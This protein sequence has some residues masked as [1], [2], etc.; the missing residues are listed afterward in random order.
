MKR[1]ASSRRP[2]PAAVALTVACLCLA[3]PGEAATFSW[4]VPGPVYAPPAWSSQATGAQGA[5]AW[6][7]PVA[8]REPVFFRKG[9]VLLTQRPSDE[10]RLLLWV[11]RK[12]LVRD[13]LPPPL[14]AAAKKELDAGG[15]LLIVGHTDIV[16]PR[17]L[18]RSLSLE[19]ARDV[20]KRL[21]AET[22]DAPWR[23]QIMGEGEDD[24]RAEG[25]VEVFAWKPLPPPE[26]GP[27]QAV[28]LLSPTPGD[29]AGSQLLAMMDSE[30]KEVVL[31]RVEEGAAWVWG[32][33]NPSAILRMP[34]PA[35]ALNLAVGGLFPDGRY[36]S[37]GEWKAPATIRELT[38]KVDSLEAGWARLSGRLPAGYESLTIWAGGI[39]YP[40]P[41]SGGKF[42]VQVARFVADM[43]V[44]AQ[45]VDPKGVTVVGPLLRLPAPEEGAPRLVAVLVWDGEGVDLDLHAWRGLGHTQPSDPD[46]RLSTG[47]AEGVRLLFDGD[48]RGRASAL[49]ADD[50][51][52]DLEIEVR[53]FS[54]LG[55]G[56]EATLY[57]IEYPADP[58]LRQGRIFG[59][60]RLS[61]RPLEERWPALHLKGF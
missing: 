27:V 43:P 33:E 11:G 58:L 36:V 47:V 39:P 15:S 26:R 10:L 53:C 38:L 51:T 52:Q 3:G 17:L 40:V 13:A 48:D 1:S 29:P 14:V 59:P 49:W 56:A 16:G 54:D 44:Y 2:R 19:Y 41:A 32:V 5:E 34:F 12:A 57:L 55:K 22:G 35:H 23:F 7:G 18:N 28:N 42:D 21:A 25:G 31:G 45:A 9:P 50:G 46:P 4:S 60:R 24:Y 20:A 8:G 6:L 37:E 61:M 30:V